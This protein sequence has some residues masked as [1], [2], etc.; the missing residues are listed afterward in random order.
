MREKKST[1]YQKL[2]SDSSAGVI[3]ALPFIIGFF[4]FLLV[5]MGISLYYSFCDYDIL[6]PARFVGL[7]NYIKMFTNDE[8]FWISLR[9]T[10]YFAVASVPLRLIFA[11]LVAMILVKTSKAN[12]FY[13]AAYYLP[14]IIGGSVAVSVLWKRMFE[15]DGVVNK[16]LGAIGI[17]ANFSWLGDKRTAIWTLILL[18]VWQFG[19]SM[20]IFLS[21]LKQIPTS[22]YE[23]AEV[24]GANK[25]TR[26]FRITL[27]LLTPTIF[28]N[29]VM[30]IIS[31]FLA[32]T[33][34][35]I[36]TQGKPMDTTLFY[37]VYMYRQSF[38]YN[39]SG[40]ASAMAWFM[41]L[42][43]S[44]VTLL[45]FKSKKYWVYEQE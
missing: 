33:Q 29:M 22:L 43:I 9:A 12:G 28:F 4:T 5:P 34:S 41:L 37:A 18:A 30:Q 26:F 27:P 6:S 44:V 21:S 25:V 24:D 11:L 13:R 14:S 42:L 39:N 35:F 20:L 45:L 10:L 31:G 17:E 23:A 40:Y 3:F 16:L 38:S 32:F 19:S 7:K 15:I 8:T 1:L 2:N 36:I